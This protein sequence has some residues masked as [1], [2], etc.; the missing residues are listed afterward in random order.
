[1]GEGGKP[2]SA[3]KAREA[4]KHDKISTT[5]ANA[6]RMQS[7]FQATHIKS[8]KSNLEREIA[9]TRKA[10]AKRMQS[11]FQATHIKS[12]KSNLEIF[13]HERSE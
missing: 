6:K 8:E 1:M 10:N 5:K 4:N 11:E 9:S 2:R 12:E 7:E 3:M 13:K